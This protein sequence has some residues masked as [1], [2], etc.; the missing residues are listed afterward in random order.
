MKDVSKV[1]SIRVD[2]ETYYKLKRKYKKG[3][4][5][6]ILRKKIEEMLNE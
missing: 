5:S 4:L 3:D 2:K 1:I 6:A